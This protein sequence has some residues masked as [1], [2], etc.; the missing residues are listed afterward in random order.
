[1]SASCL[2]E[3][4]TGPLTDN[5]NPDPN[6]RA[7]WIDLAKKFKVPIRCVWF[8]TPVRLCEHNDM[9]RAMN[10]PVCRLP[11]LTCSMKSMH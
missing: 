6:T 3:K 9:V 10:Q 11:F 5:T 4:L 8:K 2:E 7:Q 1:M